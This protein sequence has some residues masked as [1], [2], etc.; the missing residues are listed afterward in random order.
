LLIA[1]ALLL[2]LLAACAYVLPDAGLSVDQR[3]ARVRALAQGG[4]MG[5]ACTLLLCL[6]T[7]PRFRRLALVMTPVVIVLDLAPITWDVARTRERSLADAKPALLADFDEDPSSLL[8]H[9]GEEQSDA[10]FT[11]SRDPQESMQDA[12]HPFAGLRW[13]VGYGAADDIDRM[14]W[15]SAA[16]RGAVM[17]ALLKQGFPDAVPMM[18]SCGIGRVIALAPLSIAGLHEVSSKQVRDGPTVH[19]YATDQAASPLVRIESGA[20]KVRWREDSPQRMALF[21]QATEPSSL[22]ILRNALPGWTALEGGREIPVTLGPNGLIRIS[23]PSG[24]HLV[25]ISYR[26]PGLT[27]GAILSG[28]GVAVSAFS[29]TR[30][31]RFRSRHRA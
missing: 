10:Y 4:A 12:L 13:G 18:R 30:S 6:L 8:L 5:L 23:V 3:T 9:L 7:V 22:I 21:V 17:H 1:S 25:E 16:E 29:A 20:G 14:G 27:L 19:L 11:A 26:P 31:S 24:S 15:K 2:C 28:L